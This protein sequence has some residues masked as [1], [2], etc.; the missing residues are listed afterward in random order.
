M[1]PHLTE[2]ERE[3]EERNDGERADS[4]AGWRPDPIYE[5]HIADVAALLDT[6]EA[7]RAENEWLREYKGAPL[8]EVTRG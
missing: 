2:S 8:A 4:D 5:P 7:L 6:V 3:I 1:R